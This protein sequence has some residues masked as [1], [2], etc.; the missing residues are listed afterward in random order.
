MITI[1]GKKKSRQDRRHKTYDKY[2]EKIFFALPTTHDALMAFIE[3]FR[4]KIGDGL[5]SAEI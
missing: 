2:G 4:G 1:S 3:K 5:V